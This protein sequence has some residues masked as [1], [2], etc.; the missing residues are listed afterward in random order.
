MVGHIGVVDGTSE[1]MGLYLANA[2]KQYEKER[3]LNP[4][5]PYPVAMMINYNPNPK[6]EAVWASV[7][8]TIDPDSNNA[9][10][11]ITS[12]P[13]L[14]EELAKNIND[15]LNFKSTSLVTGLVIE[16]YPDIEIA[17]TKYK[18]ADNGAYQ[19]LHELYNNESLGDLVLERD[20]A[21]AFKNVAPE[22][23]QQA[24]VDQQIQTIKI[25][26]QVFDLFKPDHPQHPVVNEVIQDVKIT[27]SKI[28]FPRVKPETALAAADYQIFILLLKEKFDSSGLDKGLNE[29]AIKCFDKEAIQG[30]AQLKGQASSLPFEKLTLELPE[31]II[32]SDKAAFKFNLKRALMSLSE[33][34]LAQMQLT[35][36][37]N[38]FNETDIAEI[39]DFIEKNNIAINL[40]LPGAFATGDYQR[41][42]DLASSEAILNRNAFNF[43]NENEVEIS[44]VA[45]PIRTR[46]VLSSTNLSIDIELQQEVQ[47]EVAVE[48]SVEKSG[49]V[50]D[51]G[52]DVKLYNLE[53]FK[54]GLTKG[55]FSPESRSYL[56]P[57]GTGAEKGWSNWLGYYDTTEADSGLQLSKPAL[58]EL[59]RHADKFQ[60]GVG[61]IKKGDDYR[62]L[63][64]GFTV[65]K[66]GEQTYI[67]FNPKLKLIAEQ[68]LLAVQTKDPKPEAALSGVQIQKWIDANPDHP[69]KEVWDEQLR[70]PKYDKQTLAALQI[71]L[72]KIAKMKPEQVTNLFN[73]CK[74]EGK[75]DVAKFNFLVNDAA[76]AKQLFSLGDGEDAGVKEHMRRLFSPQEQLVTTFVSNFS[77]DESDQAL[78]TSILSKEDNANVTNI[79]SKVDSID[80]N[81]L[82]QLYLQSGSKGFE[83]L[84]TLLNL[85]N[86][87][88][89]QNIIKS[90][91]I[92]EGSYQQILTEEFQDAL[93]VYSSLPDNERQFFTTLFEQHA[94]HNSNVNFAQ[95]M[96]TFVK[97][98]SELKALS[99]SD[100]ELELPS[101]CNLTNVKS[102]PLALA[103]IVALVRHVKNED[104]Q[105]QLQE[106]HKLDLS[107]TGM[108][109]AI[110]R[111]FKYR[112]QWNFVTAEMQLNHSHAQGKRYIH[113]NA[114][115]PELSQDFLRYVAFQS[116]QGSL[117]LEFYKHADEKIKSSSWSDDNKLYFYNLIAASATGDSNIR[118]SKNTKEAIADF[119]TLFDKIDK[120]PNPLFVGLVV[121]K[122]MLREQILSSLNTLD[123]VPPLPVLSRL[124]T[125]ISNSLSSALNLVE[126]ANALTEANESLDKMARKEQYGDS[127]YKGMACYQK[128]D[129]DNSKLFFEHM[130]TIEAIYAQ[131]HMDIK[132]D[133]NQHVVGEHLLRLI[134]TFHIK[135]DQ[136]PRNN[137]LQA[138]FSAFD[139]VGKEHLA[140][141]M[142][143]LSILTK[144]DSEKYLNLPPLSHK[145]LIS[146]VEA[147]Q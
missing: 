117:G 122:D 111:S 17:P 115:G 4:H 89:Y 146:L 131:S 69:F 145:H 101:E 105:A 119:N 40:T 99:Q 129:Y 73:L 78:L 76:K 18:T 134:S 41:R 25:E 77:A 140:Q 138:V 16:A 91:S 132:N 141:K 85:G 84:S 107:S 142:E 147:V 98:K 127:V 120:P 36:T 21:K 113:I 59:M 70:S 7:V 54:E 60:Y 42:V 130:A 121:S 102:M 143:L 118:F 125:L 126:N 30:I 80:M 10:Y 35:D 128:S 39:T 9:S 38:I 28:T 112:K 75:I 139:N 43:A 90:I 62:N 20:N 34:N 72:P 55:E 86:L 24:I 32:A 52:E 19:V 23:A 31:T 56:I 109:Q 48:G 14:N 8:I 106:A 61:F 65:K 94:Q 110:T 47:V 64:A 103:R 50:E 68:N 6:D 51:S 123:E 100:Q 27:D 104:R 66:Q 2:K 49:Q 74:T 144:I 44:K 63:P 96:E 46:P 79:K 22:L 13:N 37:G 33:L 124:V 81:G 87:E 67:D 45:R 83:N 15:A 95:L 12:G 137:N 29:L 5:H 108:I 93:K 135:A 88:S 1:A 136:E 71:A 53:R 82:L 3:G 116:K 97:F 57:A 26:P 58:E 11:E 92:N 133:P 114:S